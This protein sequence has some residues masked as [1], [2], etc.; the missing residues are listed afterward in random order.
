MKRKRLMTCIPARWWF[1]ACLL[2][3]L[4][5]AG[6]GQEALPPQPEGPAIQL[7]SSGEETSDCEEADSNSIF[8]FG[9]VVSVQD[10]SLTIEIPDI[11]PQGE[12]KEDLWWEIRP[13]LDKDNRTTT[14]TIGPN[15]Q[16][17][18]QDGDQTSLM[19]N[20]PLIIAG[21]WMGDGIAADFIVDCHLIEDSLLTDQVEPML[22]GG[23]WSELTPDERPEFLDRMP[24]TERSGTRGKGLP[25]L[26]AAYDAEY[27]EF[28]G[29]YGF[30]TYA[31]MSPDIDFYVVYAVLFKVELDRVGFICG[32]GGGK[33]DFPFSFEAD[34]PSALLIDSLGIVNVTVR[35]QQPPD[36]EYS[37][38]YA[39]GY[40]TEIR[41]KVCSRAWPWSKWKCKTY[42]QNINFLS[43]VNATE[44]PAPMPGE[45]LRIADLACPGFDI[46][47]TLD[48]VHDIG[49][50]LNVGI[51]RSI[52]L[53]GDTFSSLVCLNSAPFFHE[54]DGTTASFVVVPSTNPLNC[55]LN[56]FL[57]WPELEWGFSGMVC[58]FGFTLVQTPALWLF[59]N[60]TEII[61]PHFQDCNDIFDWN[62]CGD[63]Q[64]REVTLTLPVVPALTSLTCPDSVFR[65]GD[66]I[67]LHAH[68][69][70]ANG[71][72]SSPREV[73]FYSGDEFLATE[74]IGADEYATF[75]TSTLNPCGHVIRAEYIG[76]DEHGNTYPTEKSLVLI[77][78]GDAQQVGLEYYWQNQYS[79]SEKADVEQEE[80]ECYLE[81]VDHMS[82]VFSEARDVSTVER[83][84]GVLLLEPHEESPGDQLDQLL[85]LVWLN[86]AN[87][88]L[89]LTGDTTTL[90]IVMDAESVRL[91]PNSTEEEL[92]LWAHRL[93]SILVSVRTSS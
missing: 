72:G 16:F 88:G 8:L 10:K 27:L 1:F 69:T 44:E 22:G 56:D 61:P 46:G 28:K 47:I 54:F 32:L 83:A 26:S 14:V 81:I 9:T 30:P 55:T 84:Y 89:L 90:N 52:R 77:V 17:Q 79:G 6:C 80:L 29:K 65:Y 76:Y 2:L 11:K 58:L 60:Q 5:A 50:T 45:T 23:T 25:T 82:T 63:D 68:V 49:I 15:T 12:E 70:G 62:T 31:W 4:L 34:A 36:G 92:A 67:T 21:T 78:T 57:Y 3:L 39:L 87:G 20:M 53:L 59:N 19:P 66:L 18:M 73:S 37:A 35:P 40:N 48:P 64:P 74:P 7:S 38:Y 85:L 86:F 75:Q 33:Y 93:H 41:W 51:C 42:S 43:Q 71:P 91:N 24:Q 13:G